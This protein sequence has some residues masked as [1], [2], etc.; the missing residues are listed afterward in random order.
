MTL[1]FEC[2]TKDMDSFTATVKESCRQLY[3]L[4]N[5]DQE[6]VMVCFFTIF[7]TSKTSD[8]LK[9]FEIIKREEGEND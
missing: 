8:L 2:D 9:V 3:H 1:D 7:P 6:K 5:G 4:C